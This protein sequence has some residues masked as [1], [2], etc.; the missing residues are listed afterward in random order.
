M[1]QPINNTASD[2][3]RTLRARLAA[4][5]VCFTFTKIDGTTRPASGTTCL[6]LIPDAFRPKASGKRTPDNLVTYFDLDRMAWRSC[7]GDLIVSIDPD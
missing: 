3:S 2:L 6:S 4:G 7:R 1:A 5:T